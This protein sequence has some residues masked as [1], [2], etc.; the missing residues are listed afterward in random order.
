M[1]YLNS[2]LIWLDENYGGLFSLIIQSF[3][4]Y[5]VYF[6]SKKL[7]GTAKLQHKDHIKAISDEHL[8]EINKEGLNSEVYLVNIKRYFK[9]YPS[10]TEKR[11]EGY[12]H[13][14]AEIKATRFD[15]IEFFSSPPIQVYKKQNGLLSFNGMELEKAFNVFPVGIIPY[16]WIDYVDLRGDE[17]AYVPLFYCHYN[18]RTHWKFWRR[19]LFFGYPYKKIVYYKLNELYQ[20]DRDPNDLRYWLVSEQIFNSKL[21]ETFHTTSLRKIF[22]FK[23]ANG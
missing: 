16:E 18:G 7:S 5:H 19:L 9:D 4:A 17:Y 20:E 23:R 12:S 11:F 22:N 8:L 15:G 10:N 21:A 14:R 3:I 13:I 1:N 2:F 6:L